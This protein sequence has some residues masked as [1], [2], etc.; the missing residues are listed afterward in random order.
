MYSTKQKSSIINLLKENSDKLLSPD[1]ISD[2][3]KEKNETVGKATL[4]R[5]L[6]NLVLTKEVRKSY[7]PETNSFEYQLCQGNCSEHLHLKCKNCGIVI[8]LGCEE[9]KEYLNHISLEHGF[10]IDHFSSTIYGLC[11]KCRGNI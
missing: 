8:H 10:I 6:D 11:P 2:L 9:T 4:Y 5:Y 3:L 1:K 7:N